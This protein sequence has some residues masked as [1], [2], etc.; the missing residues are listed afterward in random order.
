MNVKKEPIPIDRNEVYRYLGYRGHEADEVT[1]QLVEVCIQELLEAAEPKHMK[2]EYPC[3]VSA[4]GTL[5]LGCFR[6]NSMNL[7]KNLGG[8]GRVLL[9][10]VTL[11]L[12]VDRLLVKYGKLQV[13]KAVI[14]QAAA[15]AM[16]ESYCNRLCE[17]WNTE[18]EQ[19][20]LYLR[21]RYSPGYG[22]FSLDFQ[23]IIL[24]ELDAGRK[25][26]ITLTDGCLMVPTKSVTAVI[27]VSETKHSCQIE[28]CEV[29]ENTACLYR[30]SNC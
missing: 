21:P 30:R 10:T 1:K 14:L 25:L 11:G 29:C 18:Y 7:K 16:I 2:K 6:T 24:D 9:M 3:H 20:K 22:D 17:E 13:T 12:G 23:R 19:K 4:D 5:D 8:C 28:G 26:G 15:A 27:G